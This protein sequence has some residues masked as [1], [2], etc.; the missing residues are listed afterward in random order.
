M[1]MKYR[2]ENTGFILETDSIV[3][4]EGWVKLDPQPTTE[5]V[6]EEKPKRIKK[7]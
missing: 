5:E 2:N 7:K 1:P 4:A 6:K 3:M